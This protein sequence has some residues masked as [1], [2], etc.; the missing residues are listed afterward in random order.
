MKGTTKDLR[1]DREKGCWVHPDG[2]E[3][4][5]TD[6]MIM[7]LREIAGML[8]QIEAL[9]EECRLKLRAQGASW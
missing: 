3:V 9:N 6:L 2:Q 8:P 5:P 1:F 7:N 4:T